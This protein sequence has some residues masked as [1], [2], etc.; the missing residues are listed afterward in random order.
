MKIAILV[1]EETME[2]CTGKGCLNAFFQK[3]DAFARYEG[4]IELLTFSHAGG[5]IDHKIESMIK[6][7]VDVVH[8][9]TC[10]RSKGENYETLANKLSANF[11]VVGYT[12]GSSEGKGRETITLEKANPCE[13]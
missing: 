6:N 13:G 11:D 8:I 5:D 7:G 3:K 4:E 9:S 10:L 12:H 2:R 1:R